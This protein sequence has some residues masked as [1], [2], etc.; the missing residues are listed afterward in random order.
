MVHVWCL[1]TYTS[2]KNE[3]EELAKR[4]VAFDLFGLLR[5]AVSVCEGA[6]HCMLQFALSTPLLNEG[7]AHKY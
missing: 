1:L 4:Y 2:R 6:Q 7:Q 5:E 3:R